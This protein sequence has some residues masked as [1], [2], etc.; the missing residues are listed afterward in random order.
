MKFANATML[1]ILKIDGDISRCMC[2]RLECASSLKI[3]GDA[4]IYVVPL[5]S[6]DGD[7][8]MY[9]VPLLSF[10]GDARMY[11]KVRIFNLPW[12]CGTFFNLFP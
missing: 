5:L 12:R 3:D 4:K 10:D 2:R 1:V 11:V 6:F 8:R 7:A 9:V